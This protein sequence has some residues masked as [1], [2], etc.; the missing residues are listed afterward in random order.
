MQVN[1]AQEKDYQETLEGMKQL[2][3]E[4]GTTVQDDGTIQIN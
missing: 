4:F 1:R 2:S 3:E